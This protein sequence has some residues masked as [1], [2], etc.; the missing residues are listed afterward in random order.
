MLQKQN[1]EKEFLLK[2]IHHRVKNNLG[3]V[4]SLLS[5]Q[6]AQIKDPKVKEEMEKGQNR[7]YSMSMIHQKLYQGKDLSIIEMKD[8]FMEL[9]DHILNSFDVNVMVDIVYDM[10][11]IELDV[12]TAVPL[13]LI[14]NELL[15]N[16]FKYAF[17]NKSKGTIH[18]SLLEIQNQIYELIVAD[19]GVGHNTK[20][21]T[22]CIGFGTQ[23]VSLLTKQL[24]GVVDKTTKN[25]TTVKIMFKAVRL[26]Q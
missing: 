13:G 6:T 18:I 21:N 22:Q 8:Y 24:D 19:N 10:Q 26:N 17:P 11:N 4:S 15:T 7:V 25:G 16:A 23:L 1:E 3:I 12:D 9:G 2:E 14:V 20:E 5:L